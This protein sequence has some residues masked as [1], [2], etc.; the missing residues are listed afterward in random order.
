MFK[1][2]ICFAHGLSGLYPVNIINFDYSM[3]NAWKETSI[4]SYLQLGA[5]DI[6]HIMFDKHLG[7]KYIASLDSDFQRAR[8]AI[9]K[10]TGIEVLYRYDN[11]KYSVISLKNNSIFHL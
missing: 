1:P 4:F 11:I 6:M 7:C 5:T 9:K 8:K 3:D 10:A 2:F